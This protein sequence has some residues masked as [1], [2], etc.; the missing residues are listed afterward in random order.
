MGSAES[1]LFAWNV[2][3]RNGDFTDLFFQ[4]KLSHASTRLQLLPA[5]NAVR[6][7]RFQPKM[8][9]LAGE[10]SFLHHL[11]DLSVCI[12]SKLTANNPDDQTTVATNALALAARV[13]ARGARS[14]LLYCDHHAHLSSVVG[15][16]YRDLLGLVDLVVCPS[17]RMASLA[18]ECVQKPPITHVVEDS[19]VVARQSFPDFRRSKPCRI[20]W[21]GSTSNLGYLLRILPDVCRQCSYS[22]SYEL[23]ILT[24]DHALNHLK[25]WCSK[26]QYKRPWTFRFVGWARGEQPEQLNREL[27]RAHVVLIPSDPADPRKAGVSHNR[28]VDSIQGGCVAIASPMDSYRELSRISLL[29]NNFP[30]LLDAALAQYERLAGKYDQLRDAGLSRFMPSQVEH[31]WHDILSQK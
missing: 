4:G 6:Q 25:M 12:F 3:G 11:D 22:F 1:I 24:A 26:L 15:S 30:E 5:V 7:L 9:S 29:G 21:F 20:L 31:R 10:S 16:L 27:G 23:T 8:I 28:L 19:C 17:S 14:I 18:E 2:L 13:K